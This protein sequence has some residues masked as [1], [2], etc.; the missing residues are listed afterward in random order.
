MMMM[1]KCCKWAEKMENTELRGERRGWDGVKIAR[2]Q[3]HGCWAGTA[4]SE[5]LQEV[6]Q[7]ALPLPGDCHV[8]DG[9]V[10]LVLSSGIQKDA[11][12]LRGATEVWKWGLASSHYHRLPSSLDQIWP[13]G[14]WE[15]LGYSGQNLGKN[16]FPL[17]FQNYSAV[18]SSQMKYV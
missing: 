4:S 8:P 14:R 11:F 2:V 16:L 1:L 10:Q 13:V 7:T 17:Y 6:G 3:V 15:K 9:P 12:C 18:W 5:S